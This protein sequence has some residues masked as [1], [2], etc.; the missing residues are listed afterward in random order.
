MFDVKENP[1]SKKYV[2]DRIQENLI[3]NRCNT[4]VLKSELESS[5][6]SY[7]CLSCDEDLLLVEVSI[8]KTITEKETCEIYELAA[9][10]LLLDC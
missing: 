1:N 10:I 5:G 3:C 7:Q 2:D 6:Y 4:H 9:N 8:G